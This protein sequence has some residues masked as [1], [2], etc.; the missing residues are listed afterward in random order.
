VINYFS[1]TF[2]L[3]F[4]PLLSQQSQRNS[5]QNRLVIRQTV[6]VSVG[7]QLFHCQPV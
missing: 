3:T 6:F 5:E 2:Q 4:L 7:T 1:I